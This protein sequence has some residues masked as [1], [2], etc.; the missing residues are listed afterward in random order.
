MMPYLAK[1]C[2]SLVVVLLAMS[3]IVFCLQSII[4]ADPARAIAGPTAPAAT[5]ETVRRQLGLD[6]PMILQYGRFLSQLVQG[7]LG[8]SVRT[9][10]PVSEDV[11]KYLPASAELAL[12]ALVFGIALAA[13]LALVQN[14]MQKSGWVKLAIVAAGS[15]PIFLSTLL[16]VYFLW[17]RLGWLPGA[18]RLGIRR[19]SGPTGFNLLDGFLVGRPE[20]SLDALLHLI[21]PALALALPIAVAVGRSLNG[22]L[23]D[24]MKQTYIR[25]GRGKGLSETAI[26]LRHG[27]RNAA[28]APLAMIGL[29]VGL[30][31]GNLLIVERVFSWPG[32]GLY[33]VQAFATSDLPA[34]LGVSLIFGAFYI[35]I[36][37]VVEVSQSLADPRIGL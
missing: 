17:F 5:V 16:L 7:D 21:L 19:F 9:R 30:L 4:P 3:F 24:V 32:L 1:R 23:H 6:D 11:R 37:V 31:F 28:S 36:N 22:A 29:Q 26:V 27:L 13:L 35:L 15:T 25:T 12:V 33:T 8:T 20:V 18:G 34:V 2:T 10:Q 14:T